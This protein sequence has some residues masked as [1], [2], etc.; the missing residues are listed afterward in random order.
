MDRMLANPE[1]FSKEMA[2]KDIF[3]EYGQ[4][5]QKLEDAMI[6]WEDAHTAYDVIRQESD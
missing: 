2:E 5:K 6:R 1:S 4:L 3:S